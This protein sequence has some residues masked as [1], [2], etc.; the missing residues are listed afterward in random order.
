MSSTP[1]APP[2]SGVSDEPAAPKAQAG[3]E[4]GRQAAAEAGTV[5]AP[6]LT[7]DEIIGPAGRDGRHPARWAIAM[8]CAGLLIAVAIPAAF[9]TRSELSGA[10]PAVRYLGVYERGT[11]QSYAGIASFAAAT[12]VTPNIVMYYSSWQESFQTSFAT[13]A[14]EHGATPLVQINPYNVSLAAIASGQYD[15]YL[16]SYAQAVRAYKHQVIMSFGHEMNGDWYPWAYGHTSSQDFVA[17]WRHL[18]T[19]FR[20]QGANNVTWLWTVNIVITA[21]GIPSP[22]PWWPGSS[23]VNWVGIDGYYSNPSMTFATLFGPTITA[24]KELTRDPILIAETAA[25][26]AAGQSA[27]IQDLFQG[28]GTYGLLGFVWFEVQPWSIDTPAAISAYR[29]GA[30]AYREPAP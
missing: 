21:G 27:K 1:K 9:L 11:P 2:A 5:L 17:A 6:A 20:S 10:S 3:N 24:V 15:A 8:L 25:T 13:A 18:V 29:R 30:Q 19:L 23:Y 7:E 22:G 12:G 28:I 14:E 16:T 26:P 4:D